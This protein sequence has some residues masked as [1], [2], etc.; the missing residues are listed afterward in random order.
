MTRIAIT[1]AAGRMGR[2]L[3]ETTL[4]TAGVTLAAAFEH[5]DSPALGRDA[6]A[7]AG[8][9]AI[10]IIV[11]ASPAA[12]L[13]RF[14]VLVDFTA[15]EATLAHVRLCRSAGRR[16][17]IGTTGLNAAQQA[18]VRDAARDIAIVHAP[19]MS[20]GVNLCFKLIELAARVLG[21]GSDIEIIEAHHAGKQDA[22]SGTALRLG[23]VA[24]GALGRDLAKCAVYERQGRTG[25]RRAG[26]IGFSSIRAGDI[27]GDHT[28]LFATAGERVE[29]THRAT[30]R[31]NFAAGALR[32]A[33]WIMG[34][35]HGLYDMQDVLDLK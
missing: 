3:I 12:E 7:L 1:G 8:R 26:S 31:G 29:I 15:P 21:A 28:V 5:P 2:A 19:N 6:G 34:R 13:D 16:L 10:G 35:E 25:A 11:G 30:S 18:A 9:D 17:V 20:I 4:G 33:Q 23:E 27:V 14:D 32:A 22:P 24:A